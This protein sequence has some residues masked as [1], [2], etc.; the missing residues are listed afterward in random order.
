MSYNPRNIR[1]QANSPL[2]KEVND[3]ARKIAQQNA[4]NSLESLEDPEDRFPSGVD[5]DIAVYY[6]D[7]LHSEK[8]FFFD[9]VYQPT[10]EPDYNIV[11]LMLKGRGLGNTLRDYSGFNN[12]AFIKGEPILV[13]GAPYDPG[14]YQTGVPSRALRF[15][16]PNSNYV[17]NEYMQIPDS[18]TLQMSGLTVGISYFIRFKIHDLA[19]EEG[20]ERTVF[21]KIDGNTIQDASMFYITPTGRMIF[22]SKRSGILYDKMT[23]TGTVTPGAVNEVFLTFKQ[24]DKTQH[25]YHNGVDKTLTAH[26]GTVL[27]QSDVTNHDMWIFQRGKGDDTEGMLYGDFFDMYVY[28][29]KV[30]TQTEVDNFTENKFT[31]LPRDYGTCMITNHAEI[32]APLAVSSFTS[33]SFMGTSFSV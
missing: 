31:I 33:T 1:E 2:E 3:I 20:I 26:G 27:W 12:H 7:Q 22:F 9:K 19:F 21:E 29:N 28:R 15:N 25:I 16:R 11:T 23:A 18:T 24:S 17:N 5:D 4:K 6:N 8:Q 13:D 30:V 10:Y 32:A 14:V